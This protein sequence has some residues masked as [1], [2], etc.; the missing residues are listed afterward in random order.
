MSLTL[1]SNCSRRLGVGERINAGVFARP[2]SSDLDWAMVGPD[3]HI[4]G[5]YVADD[6][7]LEYREYM[8]VQ[9]AEDAPEEEDPSEV[10]VDHI[11]E[12]LGI[13]TEMGKKALALALRNVQVL[14]SKQLDY[15]SA[16]IADFGEYGVLVRANDKVA[17]LKNL[18]TNVASPQNESIEDSWLDLSNYSLI[19][20]LC[21]RGDWR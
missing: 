2:W 10:N 12:M 6:S 5:S 14:D 7:D 21:R 18:L 3:D 8:L 4:C 11:V 13:R 19:A 15:G 20:V 16:N 9:G 1:D 17:R